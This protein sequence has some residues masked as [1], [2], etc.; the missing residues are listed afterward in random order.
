MLGLRPGA[1]RRDASAARIEPPAPARPP[2]RLASS[3]PTCS[4]N[5]C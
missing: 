1:A 5:S 2:P 3:S 4:L